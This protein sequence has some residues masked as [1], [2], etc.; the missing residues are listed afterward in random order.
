L[1]SGSWWNRTLVYLGLKEEPED[2]YDEAFEHA[3]QASDDGVAPAPG[4]G[5]RGDVTVRALRPAPAPEDGDGPGAA[6]AR[7]AVVEVV[8]FE[9]VESVG[10]R[11]RTGQPVVFDASAADA[12][13][14]RRVVDFVS[15]M[16][17]V[18]RGSLEKVGGRAFL[19]TPDGVHLPDDERRRLVGLGYRLTTGGRA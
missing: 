13:T 14:A 4:D 16:T 11:F 8:A 2:A 18:A 9:D 3:R 6:A 10:A 17:Y 7:A 1:S 19:L 15:G 12:T 5:G